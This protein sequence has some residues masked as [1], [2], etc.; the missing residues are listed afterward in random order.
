MQIP[1][2]IPILVTDFCTLRNKK[3]L[4]SND[5]KR[6]TRKKMINKKNKEI[7]RHQKTTPKPAPRTSHT[8]NKCI[9]TLPY[10]DTTPTET[11]ATNPTRAQLAKY[12]EDLEAESI[13]I[14]SAAEL[15]ETGKF[16]LDEE[17]E[18]EL[19]LE[20]EPELEEPSP[21]PVLEEEKIEIVPLPEDVPFNLWLPLWM[22]ELLVPLP[23]WNDLYRVPFV[24]FPRE[25]SII[26]PL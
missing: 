1:I 25:S 13:F 26:V 19:E 22:V 17:E 8:A 23:W 24:E 11:K 10:K 6:M 15:G 14:V 5:S 7:N 9:P 16:P 21:E 3:L 4:I 18:E 2:P 20:L 12:A